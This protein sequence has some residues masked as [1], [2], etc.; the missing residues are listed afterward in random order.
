M[1][2]CKHAML[3][4]KRSTH[5]VP[6]DLLC[7]RFTDKEVQ[8]DAKLV[9]YNIVDRQGK[10]YVQVEVNGES[11]VRWH[12]ELVLIPEPGVAIGLLPLACLHQ[13]L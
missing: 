3:S 13:C 4:R 1:Q 7:N 11:K 12:A 9:S 2:L 10:P 8:R 6:H 5:G